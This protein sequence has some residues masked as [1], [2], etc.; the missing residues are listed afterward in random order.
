MEAV[1][2]QKLYADHSA[3]VRRFALYLTGDPDLASEVTSETFLRA[4]AGR[5]AIRTETAKA[6]LLSIARNLTVDHKR[7][8]RAT[9]PVEEG[10]A[11]APESSHAAVELGRVLQEIRR[12]PSE[13]R[14]PLT[15]TAINGLTYEEAARVIGVP[16]SSIKVRIHRAR[17]KLAAALESK[18]QTS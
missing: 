8:T 9:V 13:F 6:Y 15:L 12:L 3:D 17:L 18:E 2:F 5:G 11:R 1:T 14:D 10:H 7:R 4:W 16:V